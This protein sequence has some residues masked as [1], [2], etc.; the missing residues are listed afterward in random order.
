MGYRSLNPDNI[1]QTQARL[2]QRIRQRFPQAGLGQVAVELQTVAQQASQRAE[3][4]R[5]R[6]IP[7]RIAIG[8]VLIL[9]AGALVL[10][11]VNLELTANLRNA[12]TLVQFAEAAA[13]ATVFFGAAVIFLFSLESRW[14][15]RR[16]LAA[17][18]ELRV[19]A[20]IVDMHQLTKQPE[21]LLRASATNEAQTTQTLYQLNRYLNYCIEMLAII[22]KVASL[23][24]QDFPDPVAI[25]AVDEVETLCVGLS[26]KIWQKL[27]MVERLADEVQPAY[28]CP[29]RATATPKST[30]TQT[31]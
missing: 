10:V 20:H 3:S 27:N 25:T 23:Y 19:L 18:H 17:I 7:L 2:V 6:N 31:A 11:A 28:G 9:V 12:V 4:I 26:N 1:V 14:K 21:G 8:V 15:R 30:T 24:I 13:G 22:S 5:R 29:P 16:I